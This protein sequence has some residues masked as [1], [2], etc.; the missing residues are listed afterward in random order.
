[1]QAKRVF[2]A[3]ADRQHVQTMNK[4]AGGEAKGV[5]GHELC[6]AMQAR[7]GFADDES[8]FCFCWF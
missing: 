5:A 4:F 7:L 6:I 3:E 2:A 1:M 8:S